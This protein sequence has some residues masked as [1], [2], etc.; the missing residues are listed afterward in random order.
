MHVSMSGDVTNESLY[1]LRGETTCLI[2][3]YTKRAV[4]AFHLQSVLFLA[5]DSL[6]FKVFGGGGS[7]SGVR[8]RCTLFLKYNAT[9][10]LPIS[11]I[12]DYVLNKHVQMPRN[13][14]ANNINLVENKEVLKRSLGLLLSLL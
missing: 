2:V 9:L 14:G 7:S 6:E 3:P 10:V 11:I 1:L 12:I 5:D 13:W 8:G 4:A